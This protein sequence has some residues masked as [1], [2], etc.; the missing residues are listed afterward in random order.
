[1]Y[2]ILL[3]IRINVNMYSVD[4]CE[5]TMETDSHPLRT[6]VGKKEKKQIII[7][8]CIHNIFI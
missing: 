2:Y 8:L 5:T 1:M 3:Y 6:N 4:T 7:M